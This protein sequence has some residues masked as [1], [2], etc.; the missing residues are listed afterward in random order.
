[1]AHSV[2]KVPEPCYKVY[3]DLRILRNEETSEKN[4]WQMQLTDGDQ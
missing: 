3:S 1:M 4:P 2:K